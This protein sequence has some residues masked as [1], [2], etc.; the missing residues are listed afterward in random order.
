MQSQ[1]CNDSAVTS[2]TTSEITT[3]VPELH[4]SWLDTERT[5]NTGHESSEYKQKP[6]PTISSIASTEIVTMENKDAAGRE[7]NKNSKTKIH[8]RDVLLH[9]RHAVSTF[10][11]N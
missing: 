10:L 8:C 3:F 1:T 7:D 9:S 4:S 6:S 5:S 11:Y 2:A